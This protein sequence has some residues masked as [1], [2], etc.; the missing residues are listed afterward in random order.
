MCIRT[1]E[2]SLPRGRGFS[3]PLS[4]FLS[5]SLSLSL[6]LAGPEALLKLR[7]NDDDDDD[8]DDVSVNMNGSELS[9]HEV[10]R[11]G[12]SFVTLSRYSSPRPRILF[13]ARQRC[14]FIYASSSLL[15]R[16][17]RFMGR[18]RAQRQAGIEGLC[19]RFVCAQTK[20]KRAS[21]YG[22]FIRTFI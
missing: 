16:V 8:Q 3:L 22:T 19:V 13:F 15:H 18:F 9:F 1:P 6:S 10:P 5:L 14:L 2:E 20:Y 21:F 7:D 4:L 12:H 11:H 17:Y